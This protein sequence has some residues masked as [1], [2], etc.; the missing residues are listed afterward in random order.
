MA[1]SGETVTFGEPEARSNRLAHLLRSKGLSRLDHY[2]IF[3]ENHARYVECCAAGERSGLYYTCINS[4]LTPQEVAYILN[5]SESKLL[6]TSKA[7]RDVALAALS[8]CPSVELCL[9]VDDEGDGGLI[10]NVDIATAKYPTKPI[11]DEVLGT[12]MLYSSGTTGKPKGVLRPLPVCPPSEP[13]K[14]YAFLSDLWRHVEDMTF[15]IPAPLYHAAPHLGVNLTVRAGG[16]SIIMERFDAELFLKY[17][18]RFKVTD[19]QLVPTMFSRMLKLPERVRS[20]YELSTLRMVVHGAAP[21][22]VPIKERMIEWWGPIIHEYY[23]ATERLGLAWN[24]SAEW[25][26]HRG[27]VGK[28]IL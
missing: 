6:I 28:V 12:A 19:T 22:P 17:V 21:C 3:M 5:N 20:R 25:L 18:E 26:A 2:S 14:L 13:I 11:A 16:T 1:E 7:K 15:L 24:D 23:S 9:I 10:Q 4:H 8:G 27:T